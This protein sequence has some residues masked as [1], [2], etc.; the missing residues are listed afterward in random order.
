MT[1]KATEGCEAI[2]VC[3][4]MSGGTHRK[5]GGRSGLLLLQYKRA[6]TELAVR[7]STRY[8]SYNVVKRQLAGDSAPFS[9][10]S[11]YRA[12]VSM[13]AAASIEAAPCSACATHQVYTVS[14]SL[15][16][17]SGRSTRRHLRCVL[18]DRPYQPFRGLTCHLNR[19][20]N[21]C[22]ASVVCENLWHVIIT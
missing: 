14:K 19:A 7:F 8:S 21:T 4:L 1:T 9:R 11:P 6:E 20:L 10:R 5:G 22:R 3:V 12:D 16:K 18:P 17:L 15:Y 2:L 13:H